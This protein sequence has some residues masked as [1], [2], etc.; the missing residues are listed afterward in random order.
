MS[1]ESPLDIITI[2]ACYP[3][4][5]LD[6]VPIDSFHQV[7]GDLTKYLLDSLLQFFQ[8]L[9]YF[10]SVFRSQITEEKKVAW[11]DIRT[12][13]RLKGMTELAPFEMILSRG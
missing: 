9:E 2:A 5:S 13:E 10:A 7:G 12:V 6:L 8:R 11:T 4:Q 3:F 1:S